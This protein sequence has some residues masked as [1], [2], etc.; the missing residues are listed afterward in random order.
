MLIS[1]KREFSARDAMREKCAME[2]S[3]K[4]WLLVIKQTNMEAVNGKWHG[5]AN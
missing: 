5:N 3:D 4:E 2:I 1:I